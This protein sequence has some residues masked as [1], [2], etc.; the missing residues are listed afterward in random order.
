MSKRELWVAAAALL[1]STSLCAQW[2]NEPTRGIPRTSDGKPDLAA[3][4]PRTADGHPDFTGLWQMP[5]HPGYV[6]NVAAD[7]DPADV[8]PWAAQAFDAR[9]D[10]LGKDDPGTIGCQPLGPRH[11]TGGGLVRLAKIVQTPAEIIVLFE[12]LNYRQIYLDGRVLPKNPN[13]SFMGYSVGHWEGEELL[14]ESFGF[15]DTTWLDFGGHP[16]SEAL[17]VT[18]RYRRTDLG[19]IKRQVTLSDR[20]AYAKPITV[21]SDMTLNADTELLEYVC[22]ET[23]RERFGLVGRSEAEKKVH[24]APEVLQKYVGNYDF[25]GSSPPFGIRTITVSRSGGQLFIDFNG[26]GRTPL[27][28]LS[29]NMFSPR[30]LGTYEFV[31]DASGAVSHVL[32]HGVESTE[33]AVRRRE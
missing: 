18:E 26:K 28:A 30:L 32:V 10:N 3:P 20:Q 13:S 24:V 5:F 19:H 27:V 2:L 22:A 14:V 9:L 11:I 4:A 23:P 6:I 33:Q 25:A 15:K 7:L 17:R 16:H 29:Q 31:T 21:D 12:D 8:K 1:F